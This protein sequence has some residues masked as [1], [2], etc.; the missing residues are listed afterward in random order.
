MNDYPHQFSGG[1]CQRVMIAMGLSCGPQ[2]LIADEPTTA[3]D[4]TTQAQ[5]L[6]LMKRPGPESSNTSL[7]IVTHNLG[8][9]ARY[10]QRIYVMYAGRVV[11]EGTTK[12]IFGRPR[13]PYTLGLLRSVPRLDETR[14]ADW[15]PSMACRPISS[16]CRVPAPFCPDALTASIAAEPTPGPTSLLW[17]M[18]I[19]SV[20]TSIWRLVQLNTRLPDQEEVLR[21]VD[22]EV[23][24]PHHEGGVE[25]QGRD[26]EG[27][28]WGEISP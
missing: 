25:A 16:I 13:H 2:L 28:G 7:V 21:L 4:V 23:S 9:V 10:V 18:V 14:A 27:C 5:M 17:K 1:M 22:L 6:E 8:V 3:L 11:E 26:G 12:E 19:V 15:C 24:L 20:A